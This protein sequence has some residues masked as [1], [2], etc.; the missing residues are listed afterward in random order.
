MNEDQTGTPRDIVEGGPERSPDGRDEPEEPI[1]KHGAGS[2]EPNRASDRDR[3]VRKDAPSR[4][5]D[6]AWNQPGTD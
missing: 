2:K 5:R 1:R 6:D 4:D 3:G